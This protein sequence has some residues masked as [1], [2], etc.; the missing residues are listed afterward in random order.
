MMDSTRQAQFEHI[1]GLTSAMLQKARAHEWAAVMGMEME[2]LGRL[3]D[4]FA[5]EVTRAEAAYVATA[6]RQMQEI[7]RQIMELGEHLQQ[8]L[9]GELRGLETGRKATQAYN[10]NR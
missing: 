7:N 8:Q 1:L 3:V 5:T 6:I 2:R 10:L 4:F 9:A